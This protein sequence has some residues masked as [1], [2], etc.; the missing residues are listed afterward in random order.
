MATYS[1]PLTAEGAVAAPSGIMPLP[2]PS[3]ES[4]TYFDAGE[5]NVLEVPEFGWILA[6]GVGPMRLVASSAVYNVGGLA[7]GA[8]PTLGGTG[9]RATVVGTWTGQPTDGQFIVIGRPSFSTVVTFKS[10][11]VTDGTLGHQVKIGASADETFENLQALIQ[12]SG[13]QGTEYFNVLTYLGLEDSFQSAYTIEV[14]AIDTGANTIT[15]RYVDYGAIGN[16]AVSTETAS[17]FSFA[18]ATF[19]GGTDGT[20]SEPSAGTRRY[21]YTWF[22]SVD[23][24]ETGRSP[25]ASI[26]KTTNENVAV[27]GLT[28]SADTSFDFINIYRTT[29]S[30]VEFRLVGAV[31]RASS[32]FTDDVADDDLS[33]GDAWNDL[34]HRAYAEGAVPRG[35]AL[36][37]WKGSVWTTG[38]RLHAPYSRGTV[39]VTEGSATVT[40]SGRGVTTRMVGRTFK[41]DGTSERY[42]ILSVDPTGPTAVLHTEYTGSTDATADFEIVDDYD[43]RRVR[44][45]VQFK[46]NQWPEDESP[47]QLDTDDSE[48]GTALLATKA[49][50][51]AFTKSSVTAITGEG[52]ESW[53]MSKVAEDVGCVAPG[54]VVGVEGGGVFLALD[55]FYGISPD[56]TLVSISS[57]KT[58]KRAP[59][60]GI[61]GT[62]ARISW[63]H[64]AQGYSIYDRE[65]RLVV[66]G[67][68]LDGDTTPNHEIVF[69][70]QNRTWAVYRRAAWLSACRV[71]LPD[72]SLGVIAGD[73]D[74][75]VWHVGIGESDGFYGTEAVQTLSGAQTVRTLTV[76]GTPFSTSGDGE[77]GKPVIVLYADGSTVEIGKVASNT[78]GALEL[79]EDLETAPAEDD[80][81]IVGGIAWQ[82][83]SGFATFGEEYR[84]KILRSVTLRHAPTSRGEYF[85]AFAVDDGA[86]QLCPVG[87]SIG[88]LTQS[89]GKVRH[90]TQW[91]GDTHAINVRGF[92]PGGRARIRGGVF[93]VLMRESGGM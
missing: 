9:T 28:A 23:G 65:Q 17:N 89:D 42:T 63:A 72:G 27:S 68:P 24:A 59:A 61:D 4:E 80:Q 74:G 86:F 83:R 77:E 43:A 38:A 14:S 85:F 8:A 84:K 69:D 53:E 25:I 34:L 51:F 32:S 47:G 82:A 39:A 71:S 15:L 5:M 52:P 92:K 62:V 64:I 40:F 70:L 36:A 67:V 58:P 12:G 87:T 2:L 30:G 31:P 54:M 20:G 22:R 37:L 60:Q 73:R 13:T 45:C 41:V 33:S 50:L 49:R 79:A 1:L 57:P 91:P 7:P 6:D 66:F 56:E 75:N 88:D 18:S 11:L 81:I 93:D 21:F 44:R 78:S 3:A 29:K 16:S 26:T 19:T 35:R 55:G 10:T 46:Y 76:S 48:G 90:K